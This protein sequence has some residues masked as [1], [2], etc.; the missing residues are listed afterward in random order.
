MK[1]K[2]EFYIIDFKYKISTNE[3]TF[4]GE[5]RIAFPAAVIPENFSEDGFQKRVSEILN[6]KALELLPQIFIEHNIETNNSS[7]ISLNL[8]VVKS[9]KV[10]TSVSTSISQ[11]LSGPPKE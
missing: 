4:H 8:E 1:T 11:Q 6:S 3:A 7:V 2:I 10:S 9:T 5:N